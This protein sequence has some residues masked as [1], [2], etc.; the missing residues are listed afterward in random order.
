MKNREDIGALFEARLQDKSKSPRLEVWE[1][2]NETLDAETKRKKRLFFWWFFGSIATITILLL[3]TLTVTN[4]SLFNA[5]ENDSEEELNI[6]K[7][8]PI[9]I[10]SEEAT[11]S[12]Q[13]LDE[14]ST[15][16]NESNIMFTSEGIEDTEYSKEDQAAIK[17]EKNNNTANEKKR[18]KIVSHGSKTTTDEANK[19][20]FEGEHEI[21]F[22]DGYEVE[23]NYSYYN[24]ETNETIVTSDKKV[25]DSL[26]AAS[27]AE[28]KKSE[29]PDTNTDSEKRKDSLN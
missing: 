28:A 3:T 4:T 26:I 18:T 22:D 11:E 10:T 9:D 19:L 25:I 1:K 21:I 5:S 14:N 23:T 27:K 29:I 8:S 13:M 16:N 17:E 7:E 24:S 6:Q 2:I 20:H 12:S 15:N